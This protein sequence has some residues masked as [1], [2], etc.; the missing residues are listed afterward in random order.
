MFEGVIEGNFTILGIVVFT[1]ALLGVV[2][3][4]KRIFSKN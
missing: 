3:L 4:V 1:L 2:Y